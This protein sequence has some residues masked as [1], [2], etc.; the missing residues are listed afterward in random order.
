MTSA[1]VMVGGSSCMQ[2]LQVY[3]MAIKILE[4]MYISRL[5][6]IYIYLYFVN[7]YL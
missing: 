7:I 6:N 2:A 1:P 4:Y 3:D 5:I